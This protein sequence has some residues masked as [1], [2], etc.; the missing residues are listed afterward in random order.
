[1]RD[2][3]FEPGSVAIPIQDESTIVPYLHYNPALTG[4]IVSDQDVIIGQTT[5]VYFDYYFDWCEQVCFWNM[6]VTDDLGWLVADHTYLE[7]TQCSKRS[8]SYWVSW[9]DVQVPA[10]TA[11]G[12]KNTISSSGFA[13]TVKAVKSTPVLESS[14]G[15]VK[16]LFHTP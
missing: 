7:C 11:V 13:F 6:D 14:W 4:F 15:K 1:M 10:E 8:R 16:S 2:A 3:V 5:R 12:T 9:V